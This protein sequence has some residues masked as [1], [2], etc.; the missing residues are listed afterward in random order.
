MTPK[1][2]RPNPARLN[3]TEAIVR[4]GTYPWTYKAS[5]SKMP[6][7]LETPFTAENAFTFR[8][9]NKFSRATAPD[10]E[11]PVLVVACKQIPQSC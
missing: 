2:E 6:N 7:V 3:D 4:K 1:W 10:R 8:S 11:G 5:G 9:P